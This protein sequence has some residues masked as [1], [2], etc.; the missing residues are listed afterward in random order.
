MSLQAFL[1]FYFQHQVI[2][3]RRAFCRYRRSPSVA[4]S[5][6]A[7][8]SMLKAVHSR[9]TASQILLACRPFPLTSFPPSSPLSFFL[10]PSLSLP[11]SLRTPICVFLCCACVRVCVYLVAPRVRGVS[12]M[13]RLRVRPRLPLRVA[14][15]DG[16]SAG[17]V[18]LQR[19]RAHAPTLGRLLH[20]FLTSTHRQA[21]QT[22]TSIRKHEMHVD[23]Y[24]RV[25]RASKHEVVFIPLL[26]V[27][28]HI[29]HN[30]IYDAISSIP[31]S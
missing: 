31:R 11:P 28:S 10:P 4:Y 26:A 1:F 17:A 5:S 14:P 23:M 22:D 19:R 25:L 13:S 30:S 18:L 15:E 16:V 7:N 6:P 24:S 3:V 27:L 20:R 29:R 8:G 2:G 21:H 12:L 9:K